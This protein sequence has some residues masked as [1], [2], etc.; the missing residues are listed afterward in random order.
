MLTLIAIA[1]LGA[2]GYL[3]SLRVHPYRKCRS[4]GT[5]GRHESRGKTKYGNCWRCRNRTLTRPGV[6]VLMPGLYSEIQAKRHG[7]FH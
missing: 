7:R 5:S 3:V 1:L 4:C 2:G 6:R